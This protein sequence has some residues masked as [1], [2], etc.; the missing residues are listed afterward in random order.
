[1]SSNKRPEP[2]SAS[3]SASEHGSIH[4]RPMTRRDNK[5]VA[6]LM[7]D[8]YYPL[9]WFWP[10]LWYGVVFS[11]DESPWLI[12]AAFVGLFVVTRDLLLSMGIVVAVVLFLATTLTT[13]FWLYVK[14]GR[15]IATETSFE[16]YGEGPGCGFWVAICCESCQDG[17]LL[18]CA[19]LTRKSEEEAEIFRMA[20]VRGAGRKGLAAK[21]LKTLEAFAVKEGYKRLLLWTSNAQHKGLRFYH[22]HGYRVIRRGWYSNRPMPITQNEMAKNIQFEEE[23]KA[24]L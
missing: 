8:V 21:L 17:P 1:M 11:R 13:Q 9:Y 2:S 18:G 22:R 15:D 16:T 10:Q 3:A 6:R 5:A 24:E 4:I 20:V 12:I 7:L 19:A 14:K 23:E